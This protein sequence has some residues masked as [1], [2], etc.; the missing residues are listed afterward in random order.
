MAGSVLFTELRT[1]PE[2]T[3][4][5]ISRLVGESVYF[6]AL[7]GPLLKH[8]ESS[9]FPHV[10]HVCF[11]MKADDCSQSDFALCCGLWCW[12]NWSFQAVEDMQSFYQVRV[13]RSQGQ[14]I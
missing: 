14:C 6:K 7:V 10:I 4:K 12:M 3:V 8:W 2:D 13:Q 11:H 5:A 9:S 1:F